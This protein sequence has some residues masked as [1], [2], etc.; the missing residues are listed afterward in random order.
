MQIESIRLSPMA[1]DDGFEQI[2]VL[3]NWLTKAMTKEIDAQN[4][5]PA[6]YGRHGFTLA[7][8]LGLMMLALVD[9]EPK[10]LH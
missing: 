8:T 1:F 6:D 9:T 5:G 7:V 2:E 3:A 10:T 4:K